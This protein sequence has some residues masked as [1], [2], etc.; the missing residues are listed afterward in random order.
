[1]SNYSFQELVVLTFNF[2][3]FYMSKKNFFSCELNK[4]P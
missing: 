3:Y 4:D 2:I 1:M